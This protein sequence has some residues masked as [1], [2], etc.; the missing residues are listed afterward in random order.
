MVDVRIRTEPELADGHRLYLYLD[1]KLLTG[2]E[3]SLE[4]KLGPPLERGV[5]SLSALILDARGK[6]VIRSKPRVFNV[7]QPTVIPPAGVGPG[8]RPKPSPK[9]AP[10]PNM[11][12]G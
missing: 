12:K 11:P 5:H 6:E 7:Q 8:L 3:N 9:P 2:E 10:R 4:Y 1:G